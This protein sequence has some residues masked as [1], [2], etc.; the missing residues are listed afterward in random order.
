MTHWRTVHPHQTRVK[1][2]NINIAPNLWNKNNIIH[3]H[4][5]NSIS[6]SESQGKPWSFATYLLTISTKIWPEDIKTFHKQKTVSLK[7]KLERD[8][9]CI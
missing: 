1:Y 8:G 4:N 2:S 9:E 5:M 7:K 6:L 3:H